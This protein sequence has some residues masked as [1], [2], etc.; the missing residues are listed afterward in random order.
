MNVF[1]GMNFTARAW[2]NYMDMRVGIPYTVTRIGD[3]GR[4]Y[5]LDDVGYECWINNEVDFL[6]DFIP[7]FT[8]SFRYIGGGLSAAYRDMTV[9]GIYQLE[10]LDSMIT[11]WVDD[12]GDGCTDSN[13]LIGEYFHQ[14]VAAESP[15]DTVM[16]VMAAR[17]FQLTAEQVSSILLVMDVVAS[18]FQKTN[19]ENQ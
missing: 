16:A 4:I 10:K 8:R 6:H 14:L 13:I 1:P 5:W 11:R 17:G 9:G 15:V 19:K 7:D 2:H 3:D 12:A 18:Q